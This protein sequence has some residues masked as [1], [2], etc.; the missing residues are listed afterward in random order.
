MAAAGHTAAASFWHTTDRRQDIRDHG[1]CCCCCRGLQMDRI[2]S[3]RRLPIDHF[4][5]LLSLSCVAWMCFRRWFSPASGEAVATSAEWET[6]FDK[7]HGQILTSRRHSAAVHEAGSVEK[8]RRRRRCAVLRFHLLTSVTWSVRIL[9]PLSRLRSFLDNFHSVYFHQS[10]CLLRSGQNVKILFYIQWLTPASFQPTDL[11]P[12]LNE[13][14]S[15][16]HW[17]CPCRW[18]SLSPHWKYLPY[19]LATVGLS[20]LPVPQSHFLHN[21]VI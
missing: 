8:C 11:H 14:V 6:S 19:P 15:P 3:L 2:M 18:K 7:R 17:N 21:L 1:C 9:Q 20:T 4:C 10:H 13:S 5:L 16:S 12:V